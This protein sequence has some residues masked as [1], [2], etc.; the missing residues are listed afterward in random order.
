MFRL[1]I[2]L[3][4]TLFITMLV[5]GRDHGQQRFGLIPNPEPLRKIAA[6]P[7]PGPAPKAAP[8]PL[9]QE[10]AFVPA[11][12]L[13]VTPAAAPAPA[14]EAAPLIAP[15]FARVSARAVNVREAP[16]TG[17]AV[18]GRLVRGDEVAV[19]APA[20]GGWIRIRIE[21]DGIDG[22]VSA[23]YLTLQE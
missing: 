16:S 7:A 10:A 17:G 11:K 5:A 1:T 3:C 18:L 21:G 12:P 23:R 6:A 22:Y 9:V 14:A 13:M 2:L 8:A 20:E 19:I 15:L 4:A